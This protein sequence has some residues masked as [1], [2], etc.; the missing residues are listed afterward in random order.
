MD[1]QNNNQEQ[2]FRVPS[3]ITDIIR[4]NE[5][6]TNQADP[7]A[8][9]IPDDQ[10]VKI[11]D[12]R[13][14]KA[15]DFF[16]QKYNL[17]ERRQ[18]NETYLFGRQLDTLAPDAALKVYE[19]RYLDNVIYEIE[20][21]IKPLAMNKL[22]DLIVTPGNDKPE[23][24]ED[25][26]NIS[27]IVDSDIKKRNN[28]VVL[29]IAFKHLPVYFTGIIKAVWDPELGQYGDYRFRVVHP[30]LV[31]IDE[32]CPSNNADDMEFVSETVVGSVQECLMKFPN[33]REELFKALQNDGLVVGEDGDFKQEDLASEIRWT[34]TWFKWYKKAET[35]EI[36]DTK[37]I[38][39]PGVKWEQIRGV[40][41]KYKN[42]VL[43][44]MKNP[45]FDYEGEEQIFVYDDP[46]Y[47]ASKR[48][49]NEEEM[50]LAAFTGQLPPNAQQER[51][52]KNYFK[53]PRVPYFFMGYDQ[54]HKIA[55]DETSRI[56]QNILNQQNLDKRGKQIAET[57]DERGKHV[58]SK[59]G[60]LAPEDI[61]K[62]DLND[63]NQDI[64]V[65]GDV[66]AVHS[67]V[68]ARQVPAQEFQDLNGTR[69]R[70]YG[71]AGANAIRG[72]IQ[73][74]T[75][76]SNQIAREADYSRADD[77]VEDTINAAAEWI[78]QWA[79]Q[80]IKLR[81]SKEHMRKLLGKKGEVTFVRLNSDLIDDGMEVL[82]KASGTDKLKAQNNAQEMAKLQLIDPLT[83]YEDMGLSD[84][85][86]RTEKLLTFLSGAA[87]GYAV[88]T[89]KFLQPENNTGQLVDQLLGAGA[90][91]S[92][93]GSPPVSPA[94]SAQPVAAP[95]AP[96]N[97]TPTDTAQ[98]PISP[99]VAPP[100]GSVRGL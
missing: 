74:D 33:K 34:E 89:M 21:S 93:Q 80:F 64:L 4:P 71:V 51:V 31:E 77:L 70:M 27:E 7:L 86:G 6:V 76:T 87:D 20:E 2:L 88:Y 79:M 42:V 52:Y 50:M 26:D 40:I 53:L 16:T 62:M 38:E 23:A 67:F 59:E 97:P 22:P 55:Y 18:R 73:S 85:E 10:L 95:Q 41:W 84:P 9:D 98:V 45:N 96:V 37:P 29:G 49:I 58:F 72:Q 8:L 17:Y 19:V 12:K 61:E 66:R 39:E 60:G 32:T 91:Q 81:Y 68:P 82:I 28:R 43:G 47:E 56:E 1:L 46:K 30:D 99:P 100:Q 25:A 92:L 11:I 75:A 69:D 78:A 48:L 3:P 14:K 90:T 13:R 5:G 94:Q 35:G 24:K 83:F 57:L 15:K 65:E 36:T 54:W 44:K 63:P